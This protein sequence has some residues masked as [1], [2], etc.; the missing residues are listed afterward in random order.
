[1][2]DQVEIAHT[3][4][5]EISRVVF[6][7]VNPVV[8][9][10]TRVAAATWVLAMFANAPTACR[11]MTAEVTVSLEASRHGT[12]RAPVGGRMTDQ[13]RPLPVSKP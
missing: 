9:L 13:V 10:T 8:V 7:E 2:L 11:N 5:A 6:V 4:L 12:S 1:M 3:N